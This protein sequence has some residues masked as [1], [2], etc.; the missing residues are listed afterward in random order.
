MPAVELDKIDEKWL[1]S[2]PP[3]VPPEVMQ[4][5][6]RAGYRVQQRRGL[7]PARMRDGRRLLFPL[8][9]VDI[10]YVGNPAL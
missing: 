7:L 2:I 10:H 4:I 9:E 1:R 8:D 5:F 3:A 6:E